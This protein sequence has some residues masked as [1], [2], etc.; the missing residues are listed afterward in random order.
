MATDGSN[1]VAD[2]QHDVMREVHVSQD[3]PGGGRI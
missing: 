1:G 2:R 3:D